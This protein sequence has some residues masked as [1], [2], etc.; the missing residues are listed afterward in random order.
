MKKQSLTIFAVAFAVVL[1]GGVA[2][3]QVGTIDFGTTTQAEAPD[4][5]GSGDAFPDEDGPEP[6][7]AEKPEEDGPR[8]EE[9]GDEADEAH[10]DAT[11]ETEKPSVE[12]DEKAEDHA[13]EA[14]EEPAEE[15]HESEEAA[16]TTPPEFGITFPK[17]GSET[18]DKVQ[19]FEGFVDD[20]VV[21]RGKYEA[22]VH[23]GAWRI[24]LVLSPGRN[25]VTMVATDF[26][27]NV[28][29]DTV[30]VY[31]VGHDKEGPKE[32]P[33]TVDFSAHQKYGS[34]GE[35]VPYDV[36]Y[37]TASP[38][39]KIWVA[40][41][42]GEGMTVAGDNGGWDLKVKFP[43]AP[44]G[45]TFEVVVETSEGDRKVFTFINTGGDQ[46]EQG[47]EH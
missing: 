47:E 30:T 36:F 33:K 28:T 8:V 25:V 17:N 42:Y 15:P 20:A 23:D 4:V 22:S 14:K 18:D 39:T 7:P 3:A 12:A 31:L 38:G 37:G 2:L 11:Q 32:E 29:K 9:H 41:P 1:I 34:C 6:P 24:E 46:Q 44:A 26:A 21:T 40:S 35:V 16:D 10:A 5:F 13:D 19:V 45:K 27:G 43:S